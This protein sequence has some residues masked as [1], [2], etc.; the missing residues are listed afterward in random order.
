MPALQPRLSSRRLTL[1]AMSAL[2]ACGGDDPAAPES[3]PEAQQVRLQVANIV[4]ASA[5]STQTFGAIEIV[6]N[7]QGSVEVVFVDPI[8]N[9][10]VHGSDESLEVVIGDESVVSWEADAQGGFTGTF[11]GLNVGATTATFRLMHGPGSAAHADFA[12]APIPFN[13]TP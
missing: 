9:P 8:G 4:L 1:F 3:H 7:N 13:I 5:S 2:F 10:V 6:R 11:R 12:S